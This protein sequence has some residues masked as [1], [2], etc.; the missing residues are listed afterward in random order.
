MPRLGQV[1]GKVSIP[2]QHQSSVQFPPGH[3][4]FPS[5]SVFCPCS[6]INIV[7]WLKCWTMFIIQAL[8]YFPLFDL[9]GNYILPEAYWKKSNGIITEWNLKTLFLS[10][11]YL[12]NLSWSTIR[13][14]IPASLP[15]TMFLSNE[16]Q[17]LW[18]EWGHYLKHNISIGPR[19][20]FCLLN[21]IDLYLSSGFF[22]DSKD[23]GK[24]I[25]LVKLVE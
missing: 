7:A 24:D 10:I 21:V 9:M 3:V 20:L 2:I 23:C 6:H 12:H 15:Q 17:Y 13:N 8:F 19:T 11:L 22:L 25:F 1:R 4:I 5:L 18:C 16:D 14:L